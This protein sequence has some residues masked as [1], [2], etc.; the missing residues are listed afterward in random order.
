[1]PVVLRGKSKHHR[2]LP[3]AAYYQAVLAPGAVMT[4]AECGHS[5]IAKRQLGSRK[6][7]ASA[8]RL[9]G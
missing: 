9:Q 7:A 3:L 5:R 1:M 2:G 4:F 8:A 6:L